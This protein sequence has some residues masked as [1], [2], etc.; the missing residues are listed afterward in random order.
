MKGNQPHVNGQENVSYATALEQM[1]QHITRIENQAREIL[2]VLRRNQAI[3]ETYPRAKISKSRMRGLK[4][5]NTAVS[6]ALR[7]LTMDEVYDYVASADNSKP[8]DQVAQYLRSKYGNLS[9]G[10]QR[11]NLGNYLRRVLL[12]KQEK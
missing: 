7:G 5:V 9:P 1:E 11:M 12:S 6:T 4:K 8:S 10:L 2:N 3:N